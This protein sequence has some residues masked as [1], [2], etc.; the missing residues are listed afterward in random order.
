LGG[1]Q[2]LALGGLQQLLANRS[3]SFLHQSQ[4]FCLGLQSNQDL[5]EVSLLGGLCEL[6]AVDVGDERVLVRGDDSGGAFEVGV[7]AQEGLEDVRVEQEGPL[8]NPQAEV[9]QEAAAFFH[10][11]LLGVALDEGGS[12]AARLEGMGG[13]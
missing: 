5:G 2:T 12:T 4:S 11:S 9:V 6:E 13:T 1:Q 7:A 8:R 3:Q 10:V